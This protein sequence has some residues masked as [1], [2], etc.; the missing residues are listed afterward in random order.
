[1]SEPTNAGEARQIVNQLPSGLLKAKPLHGAENKI[2]LFLGGTA[3]KLAMGT[4]ETPAPW[5][6]PGGAQTCREPSIVTCPV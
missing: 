4:V 1:M 5:K 3:A 2:V 6:L